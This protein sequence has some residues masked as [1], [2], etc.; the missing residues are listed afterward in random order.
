MYDYL[1]V[2]SGLF[3]SVFARQATDAGKKVL[4][5]DKRPN[6]AGNVYTEKVE[7]IN[8][9]KYGAHIFHTNN[10]EV[11][12]YVNRFATFNRFTNSP[13]ANYKGELYSM[14]F[15]MYTFN[16]MWG[17]VT[18]EEAAAKIEEQ[19]KEITGEPQNLEEQAIS[20]V[21]RDIYE[22]LV[23]GYTEKQ[24]G[25]DCKELPAFIIKRL[26]VRL[27]FDN[28]YF[29]ALY[30]GI[31]IGGY[32]KLV[33]NLLDGIEVQLNVDYLVDR[34]KWDAIAEKVVYTGAID[35]FFNYS[36]GNLEYRSVR[37]E[38]E[39]LDIPNFQGNAAVNYTDRETPWTRIIEH[40][41][42]EFGKDENGNDLPK[43]IISREYSSEWKPGDEPYYP[44]NDEKNGALYKEYR[45]LADQEGKVIFG[46]R[47][48]EYK[49]YDMDAVI[50]SAL[51]CVKREL[52]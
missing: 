34:A 46:G 16:K 1:V 21:G 12:N 50:A 27:T 40:K 51:E 33:E 44:V 42:F 2:G 4:V 15:N 48:G 38:N 43:T 11:W 31:P 45:A 10:T 25:R 26:P 41:W 49:Y 17:V 3:G 18:P 13:V 29:N 19:K 47:L 28:N 9:H 30:Q 52:R 24:W 22:K 7:G 35:A 23:K 6:I 37:F 36:L 14:P 39:V 32:T 5:I 20:L 8:F